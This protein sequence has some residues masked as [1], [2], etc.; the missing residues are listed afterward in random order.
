[1]TTR[2]SSIAPRRATVVYGDFTSAGQ[3]PAK[4]RLP[5]GGGGGSTVVS[6][7]SPNR[8]T[9]DAGHKAVSAR[10]RFA[11]LRGPGP[12]GLEPRKPKRRTFGRLTRLPAPNCRPWVII[13]ILVPRHVCPTVNNFDHALL[14]IGGKIAGVERVTA[15]GREA[16]V[17]EKAQK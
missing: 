3:L 7:P 5:S 14:V 9:C 2:R 17:M 11:D 12:P 8:V 1:L 13:Y 15:R 10:R 6:R 4:L 16:P